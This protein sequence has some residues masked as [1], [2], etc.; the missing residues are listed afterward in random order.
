ME[1]REMRVFVGIAEAGSFST[2][3]RELGLSQSA[4]SQTVS[5]LERRL[6]TRLLIRTRT[7]VHPTETGQLLLAEARAV[8]NRHDRALNALTRKVDGDEQT[9]RLGLPLDLPPSLFNKP[10]A[11]L[12]STFPGTRVTVRHLPQVLRESALRTG[13][14]DIGLLHGRPSGDDLDCLLVLDEPMGVVIAARHA[15]RLAGPDGVPLDALAGLEWV[16]FPRHDAPGF[17]DEAAAVLRNH[18]L[19]AGNPDPL[20]DSD[21]RLLI[22][23]VRFAALAS[24]HGFSLAPPHV[25]RQIPDYLTWC[26]LTGTPVVRRT[27]AAWPAACQRRNIGHFVAAFDVPERAGTWPEPAARSAA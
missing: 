6:E 10:F 15:A 16:G 19:D 2:A 17:H 9:L 12:E 5:S 25:V 20:A 18:G 21:S 4:L 27:W 23:E 8:L 3:A 24:G 1:L 7:G 26:P 14:L 22:P 13:A 11:V